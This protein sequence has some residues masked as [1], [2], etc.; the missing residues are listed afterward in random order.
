MT[1]YVIEY[2]RHHKGKYIWKPVCTIFSNHTTYVWGKTQ[3]LA[4][5]SSY[6]QSIRA[7]VR[8]VPYKRYTFDSRDI[9]R[10]PKL[11]PIK[12]FGAYL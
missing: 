12:L 7:T 4:V 3:T 6:G 11:K 2:R 10:I 1:L 9:L 5:L 8:A